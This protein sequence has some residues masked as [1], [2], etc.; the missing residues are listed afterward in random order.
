MNRRNW[1]MGIG[2][3]LVGTGSASASVNANTG[4]RS[5][6]YTV[7]KEITRIRVRSWKGKKEVIDTHFTVEPGQIFRIDAA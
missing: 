2:A 4:A 7:P 5:V 6:T 1:F 3:L